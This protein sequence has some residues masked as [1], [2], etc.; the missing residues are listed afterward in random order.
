MELL[1]D[2]LVVAPFRSP[3]GPA[4]GSVPGGRL[5]H[6]GPAASDMQ[7]VRRR[8]ASEGLGFRV[9]RGSSRES[10]RWFSRAHCF[11]SMKFEALDASRSN[12]HL[13]G[14]VK[15]N[16]V[17]EDLPVVEPA[18]CADPDFG[19]G[20]S[21]TCRNRSMGEECWAYCLPGFS[22]ILTAVLDDLGGPVVQDE[23]THFQS[24]M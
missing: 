15:G 10:L 19:E 1:F 2:R 16:R 17:R 11:R 24:F 8:V 20:A 21:S 23:T 4:G 18:A 22:G 13:N 12:F 7:P 9:R 3:Q 5:V 14:L 6:A